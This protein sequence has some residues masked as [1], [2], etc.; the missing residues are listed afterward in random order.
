MRTLM[1]VAVSLFCLA[2][3]AP[4]KGSLSGN[5]S[6]K[7]NNFVGN[8]GDVGAEVSLFSMDSPTGEI[9][10][11]A[12]VGADG[13]FKIENIPAGKYF[14]VIRSKATNDC[15]R[16]HINKLDESKDPIK[17]VFGIDLEPLV[18]QYRNAPKEPDHSDLNDK[19]GE[20]VIKAIPSQFTDKIKLQFWYGNAYDFKVIEIKSQENTAV[21]TDFGTTF[22]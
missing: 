7:Y 9:A 15:P 13:N 3:C 11:S 14:L 5:V 2:S 4:K 8:R 6:W 1:M 22:M 12:V 16:W 17:R 21:V 18:N 19:T 20:E 10:F